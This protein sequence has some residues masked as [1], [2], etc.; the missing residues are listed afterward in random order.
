MSSLD[1]AGQSHVHVDGDCNFWL[2]DPLSRP[3]TLQLQQ[4]SS[5]DTREALRPIFKWTRGTAKHR[6]FDKAFRYVTWMRQLYASGSPALGIKAQPQLQVVYA[7]NSIVTASQ[8]ASDAVSALRAY[9]E[10]RRYKFTI[11]GACK[12]D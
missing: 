1:G 10:L 5:I 9:E 8:K 2:H 3:V 7:L 12:I 4:G 6:D 11:D